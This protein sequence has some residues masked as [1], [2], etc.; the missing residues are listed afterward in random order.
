MT[1]FSTPGILLRRVDY[2]DYD[3]ILTFLTLDMG[4]VSVIAK[5]AKKSV[6]RFG[7]IL[8]LF[9]ILEIT[10]TIGK[11]KGMAVLQEAHLE[12]PHEEIRQ[13][14]IKTAYASY[15]SEIV[16]AWLEDEVPQEKIYRLLCFGLES[17]DRGI[18]TPD[19]LSIVFQIR[20]LFLSGLS[21]EL[22]RCGKCMKDIDTLRDRKFGFEPDKGRLICSGCKKGGDYGLILSKGTIKKILWVQDEVLENVARVR[23]SHSSLLE[24]QR[25]LETFLPYHLGRE[26][27]SLKFLRGIR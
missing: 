22:S 4:K 26:P 12:E 6:K 1:G 8:E 11:R 16:I 7:G 13:D 21:P 10:C 19:A 17:L 20:F 9:S 25:V 14:I 3:I 5:N 18:M 15:W 2:G 24:A 27:R 23:F